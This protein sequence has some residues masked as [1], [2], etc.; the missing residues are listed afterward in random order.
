MTHYEC[1][2]DSTR[3]NMLQFQ[4]FGSGLMAHGVVMTYF[5]MPESD[6]VPISKTI[7]VYAMPADAPWPINRE[8]AVRFWEFTDS[9]DTSDRAPVCHALTWTQEL[10]DYAVAVTVALRDMLA[11]INC[12]YG[13]FE[14]AEFLNEHRN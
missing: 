7:R 5:V 9:G 3:P 11:G 4:Q 10:E 1:E 14:T 12:A 13:P 2:Y 8:R 6:Q